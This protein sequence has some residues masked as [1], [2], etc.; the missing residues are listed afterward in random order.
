MLFAASGDL[1]DFAL[2]SAGVIAILWWSSLR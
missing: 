1:L 2:G